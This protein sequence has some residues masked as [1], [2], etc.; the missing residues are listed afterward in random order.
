MASGVPVVATRCGG[1][2]DIVTD[3]TGILIDIDDSLMMREAIIKMHS[4]FSKYNA[5]EIRNYVV[6]KYGFEPFLK[7]INS[8]YQTCLSK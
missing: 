2:D 3:K 5:E 6:N 4:H 1:P 7:Q 8:I